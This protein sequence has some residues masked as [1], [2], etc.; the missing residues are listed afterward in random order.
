MLEKTC[1][2]TPVNQT[3][4]K[5]PAAPPKD[6]KGFI[7]PWLEQLSHGVFNLKQCTQKIRHAR[8]NDPVIPTLEQVDSL[9]DQLK[10][11]LDQI[12]AIL[13]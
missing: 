10:Q 5:Q 4:G 11:I 13:A 3:S 8:P 12:T 7:Q 2:Q 9:A 1:P 6:G